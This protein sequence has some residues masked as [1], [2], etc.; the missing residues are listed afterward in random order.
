MPKSPCFRKVLKGI[1]SYVSHGHTIVW[2]NNMAKKATF[3]I[4]GNYCQKYLR[5]VPMSQKEETKP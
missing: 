2:P 3:V 4:I 5:D 1:K